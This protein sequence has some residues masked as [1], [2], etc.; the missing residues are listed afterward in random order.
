M[1]LYLSNHVFEQLPQ[2]PLGTKLCG[3]F[4]STHDIATICAISSPNTDIHYPTLAVIGETDNEYP[5]TFCAELSWSDQSGKHVEAIVYN[6]S[7]FYKRTPFS[8]TV[9]QHMASE[10]ILLVGVG[11]VGA[12]MGLELARS[13]VG[14]LIALD[15]DILEIH[16]CMRHTLGTSYIGWPK[17]IAFAEYL[18]THAPNCA[19]LPIYDDLFQDDRQALKALMEKEQ[20]TRIIAVTDSLHIQ[21]LCQMLAIKF[22]IPLMAIWCDSNA[23][24]GEIFFWEPGQARGWKEGRSKRGCYGCL[25]NPNEVGNIKRSSHFD[26]SQDDPD[27]YG[28]EPALGAF[29]NRIVNVAT[30]WMNAWILSSCSVKT[31]LGGTMDYYYEDKGLQYL[32]LGGAYA[33]NKP[34]QL[35]AKSPW[36]QDWYRVVKD[37][38]CPFCADNVDISTTLFPS[39]SDSNDEDNWVSVG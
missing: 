35:T 19:C 27:S 18:K 37:E 10:N 34:E 3:T 12:P 28:G 13:G 36:S 8:K 16:N 38:S 9:M 20:P 25:R 6:N 39:M 24:E 22:Q 2:L 21:Y 14:K 31:Q 17:S 1:Q 11:S 4:S 30:I 26:Y 7:D 33:Y 5:L 23:V 29:I 32:R 15:K